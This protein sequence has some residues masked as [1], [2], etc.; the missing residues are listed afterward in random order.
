MENEEEFE[1]LNLDFISIIE[2]TTLGGVDYILARDKRFDDIAY[3]MRAVE[4]EGDD[5]VYE[6]VDDTKTQRALM[7]IFSELS[8]EYGFEID[9]EDE[10]SFDDIDDSDEEEE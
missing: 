5:I 9:E 4:G 3:I 6:I 7:S 1:E 10:D 8:D 2:Q